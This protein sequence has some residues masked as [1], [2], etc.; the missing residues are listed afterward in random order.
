MVDNLTL[1]ACLSVLYK[2]SYVYLYF[3]NNTFKIIINRTK[4]E[5][6]IISLNLKCFEH[7]CNINDG[8][9]LLVDKVYSDLQSFLMELSDTNLLLQIPY[10]IACRYVSLDSEGV[11]GVGGC[12]VSH[13]TNY[14]IKG[15]APIGI[16][17]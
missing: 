16:S 10:R 7:T 14:D 12:E 2:F 1:C 5:K 8:V 13:P 6:I 17:I 4:C 3:N 11:G 9:Y 15:S